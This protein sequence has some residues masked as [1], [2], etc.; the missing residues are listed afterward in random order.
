LKLASPV[1]LAGSLVLR[2][3][4]AE[5]LQIIEPS[6]GLSRPFEGPGFFTYRRAAMPKAA[7]ILPPVSASST[8]QNSNSV[9]LISIA[10]FSGVGL[11]IS[12]VVVL[13]GIKGYWF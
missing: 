11:L 13:A 3:Y 5:A 12:L 9:Q 2:T 1:A 8:S 4:F 7:R 10:L 6:L